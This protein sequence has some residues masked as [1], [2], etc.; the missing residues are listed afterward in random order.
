LCAVRFPIL[1]WFL[2]LLIFSSARARTS[3]FF[4]V[5]FPV[6]FCCPGFR[7]IAEVPFPPYVLILPSRGAFESAVLIPFF[8]PHAAASAIW[9]SARSACTWSV[10]VRTQST[11][12]CSISPGLPRSVRQSD[13]CL[14]WIFAASIFPRGFASSRSSTPGQGRAHLSGFHR[15]SLALKRFPR[16]AGVCFPRS[17]ISS[18]VVTPSAG[19][20]TSQVRLR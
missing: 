4:F 5:E 17:A 12:S 1:C 14:V 19:S 9:I 8:L 3:S 7:S 6:R 16:P 20:R 11:A 13:S 15:Q 2:S 10:L 18:S